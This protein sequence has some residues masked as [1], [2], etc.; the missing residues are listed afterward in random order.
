MV[1]YV[2]FAT[3]AHANNTGRNSNSSYE[4]RFFCFEIISDLFVFLHNEKNV[5]KFYQ[6]CQIVI[7]LL[8][9]F[10]YYAMNQFEGKKSIFRV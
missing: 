1:V 2:A 6:K 3:N 4:L 8:F 7:M 5:P 9:A 10:V